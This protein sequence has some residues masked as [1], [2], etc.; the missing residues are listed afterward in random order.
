MRKE[1]SKERDKSGDENVQKPFK[2][3]RNFSSSDDIDRVAISMVSHF[4]FYW[5]FM[6][7]YIFIDR[8]GT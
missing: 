5:K 8:R 4:T 7:K 3:N 6:R 1:T 2:G